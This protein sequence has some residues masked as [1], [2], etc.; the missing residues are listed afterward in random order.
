MKKAQRGASLSAV[1]GRA[2]V[3]A[4]VGICHAACEVIT[5]RNEPRDEQ[6]KGAR[7]APLAAI[8]LAEVAAP[9][10][11]DLRRWAQNKK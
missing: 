5:S 7:G 10:M 6:S 2:K 9:V 3:G 11:V 1:A 4:N 8:G